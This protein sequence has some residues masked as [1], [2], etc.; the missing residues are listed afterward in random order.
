MQSLLLYVVFILMMLETVGMRTHVFSPDSLFF[1]TS[2]PPPRCVSFFYRPSTIHQQH[3]KRHPFPKT[4]NRTICLPILILPFPLRLATTI[5]KIATKPTT[6]I[7]FLVYRDT[8]TRLLHLFR[9]RVQP[10]NSSCLEC[11]ATTC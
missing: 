11:R 5:M 1:A 3:P 7:R 8:T 2:S 4:S 6:T 9:N 10:T